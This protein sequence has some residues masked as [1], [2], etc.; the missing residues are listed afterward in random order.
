MGGGRCGDGGRRVVVVRLG[1]EVLVLGAGVAPVAE[2]GGGCTRVRLC[3]T[4][5]VRVEEHG[6]IIVGHA[7]QAIASL[8]LTSTDGRAAEAGGGTWRRRR[9]LRAP[10][11]PI[12]VRQ[13]GGID[14]VR[15]LRALRRDSRSRAD[16]PLMI[17]A[18]SAA[19]QTAFFN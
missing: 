9:R 1:A 14:S 2:V 19:H 16:N 3:P 10:L 5:V 4:G 8:T 12:Q 18:L 7:A 15:A 13:Q 17:P 11:S 6:E